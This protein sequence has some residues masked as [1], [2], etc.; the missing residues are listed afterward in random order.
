MIDLYINGLS[1][2]YEPE[3]VVRIFFLRANLINTY[4]C[5]KK[6]KSCIIVRKTNNHLFCAIRNNGETSMRKVKIK[7]ISH[8]FNTVFTDKQ[9]QL[10]YVLSSLIYDMLCQTQKKRPPWGML[11]GVRPVRIIHDMRNAK[12]TEEKIKKRFCNLYF[13][14]EEK[15]ETALKIANLQKPII[16]KANN[17]FRPYSLYISIPFCPS[18][19]NYCSFVS[20]TVGHSEKII[21]EYVEK[22]C[23]EIEYTAK[24]ANE[25]NLTLCTIYIGGGTP[26]ALSETQLLKLMQTINNNFNTKNIQEYTVEAGRPDCTNYEKLA[27]IKNYGATRISIN[28][29]SM[30]NEVLKE[31]GR[32]HTADDII[33]CYESARAIGHKNIN[34][35]LIAG[36]NKDN[37]ESFNSTLNSIIKLNPE[38]ITIHTLTQKRASNI[39]IDGNMQ[40]NNDV[41]KMLEISESLLNANDYIP[42]YLYRQK[43]TLGNLENT[44]YTKQGFT[45][46]YNIYIMEEIHSILA[47]GAGA[48]TK[49]INKKTGEIKRIFNFKYHTEYLQRFD[50]VL[51][52]K[53]KVSEFYGKQFNLDT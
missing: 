1:S 35:D 40:Q 21:D 5:A 16:T 47:L 20:R 49:L 26:T 38:N 45:G 41:E 36:L 15:F 42:Y 11:T 23:T 53:Q 29:Q 2:I 27:I 6:H 44:G 8:E 43:G 13:A 4:P 39:V 52:R 19:C 22:L 51:F 37:C 33:K 48:S 46:L 32:K 12:K 18:R 30:N 24:I 17:F 50:E 10:E 25:Q 31:I 14:K 34:M 28:P 9:K 7:N 3:H